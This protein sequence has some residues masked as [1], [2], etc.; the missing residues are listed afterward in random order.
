M[1]P[2]TKILLQSEQ[3]TLEPE[4]MPSG[5]WMP[6]SSK[7]YDPK[8]RSGYNDDRPVWATVVAT[9]VKGFIVNGKATGW[10]LP[11]VGDKVWFGFRSW[12]WARGSEMLSPE[13]IHCVEPH[14]GSPAWVPGDIAL[15]GQINEDP[16]TDSGLVKTVNVDTESG[17]GVVRMMSE[18]FSK[19]NPSISVGMIVRFKA[20]AYGNQ[21]V[22]NPF[23][24]DDL[25]PLRPWGILAIE[26]G[27]IDESEMKA[28]AGEAARIKELLA[29]SIE[30]GPLRNEMES[31]DPQSRVDQKEEDDLRR[32]QKEFHRTYFGERI[33]H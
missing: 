25:V 20:A 14:D 31:I 9:P 8:F 10:R 2:M 21:V 32:A 22:P 15:I 13:S 27:I 23:G 28:R 17:R 16:L 30:H 26:R 12:V 33:N 5:L 24:D 3:S 4:Q 11:E 29:S 7:N 18:G 19:A 6:P 1:R